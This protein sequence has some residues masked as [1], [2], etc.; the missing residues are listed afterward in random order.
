[1]CRIATSVGNRPYIVAR[2][3]WYFDR[4]VYVHGAQQG[5]FLEHITGNP[6]VCL[7]VDRMG[8][9]LPAAT[10]SGFSLEYAGVI[11]FGQARQIHGPEE[12]QR[13]LQGLLDKYFP[14]R[15]PRTDYC[16]MTDSEVAATSVVGIDVEA[17]SGK[18]HL[19]PASA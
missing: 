11:V 16:P 9:L 1:V 12:K 14:D 4:C 2:T 5:R 17:W 7:E 13:A 6:Q 3:F 19:V 8:C 10:A 18:Q 15:Q